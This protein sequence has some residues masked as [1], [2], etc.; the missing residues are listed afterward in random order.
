MS[1]KIVIVGAGPVGSLLGIYLADREHQVEIYERRADLRKTG[2]R[3]GRSIN[4]ALSRRGFDALIPVG[5][6]SDVMALATPMKGRMIH[7]ADG[8]ITFQPYGK[9]DSEVI[10]AVSRGELNRALLNVAEARKGIK[11]TFD[12]RCLD[13][14]LKDSSVT[15]R[16][17]QSGSTYDVRAGVI[18]GADGSNSA[19]RHAMARLPRISVSQRYIEYGYKELTIPSAP[20]GTYLLEKNALHIWPRGGYM[21]IALPNQGGSF[22]STLFFPFEG[23]DSFERLTSPHD[24]EDFFGS[25]FPDAAV[26]IPNLTKQFF[27]NPTGALATIKID[28]WHLEAKVLLVGDAAHGIVPFLG[29]GLNCAFESVVI[30]AEHLDRSE[31]NWNAAFEEFNRARRPDTDAIAELALDNFIEMRDRVADAKFLLK[32][33]VELLLERKF[34]PKF[35]ARYAMIQFHHVAYSQAASRGLINERI[36]SELCDAI[37]SPDQLDWDKAEKLI[38]QLL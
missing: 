28:P 4:L 25:V 3:E 13:I 10:Y 32:K 19:V 16:D 2:D 17:E 36:L 22:T 24:V 31:G 18:F 9:D 21:L 38:G 33:N 37:D 11:I 30:L 29:Q 20:D 14:N 15:L 26:L 8:R 23:S 7:A 6:K 5:I 1:H 34:Y 27:A 35:I 12:Q